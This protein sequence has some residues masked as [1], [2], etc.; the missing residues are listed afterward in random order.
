MAH[1]QVLN[2]LSYMTP[3]PGGDFYPTTPAELLRDL[4]CFAELLEA[5]WYDREARASLLWQLG[6]LIQAL[7]Q[8]AKGKAVLRAEDGSSG[9]VYY[10][11]AG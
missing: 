8:A 1:M 3:P 10:A 5:D 9:E 11:I 4:R 2:L 6:S 7:D